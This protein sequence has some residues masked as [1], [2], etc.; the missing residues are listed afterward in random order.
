MAKSP[1]VVIFIFSAA[2]STSPTVRPRPFRDNRVVGEIRPPRLDRRAVGFEDLLIMEGLGRLRAPKPLARDRA[3]DGAAFAALQRVGNGG[4]GDGAVEQLKCRDGAGNARG[5]YEGPRGVVDQHRIGG[6]RLKP[7]EP[8]LD[9]KLPGRAAGHGPEQLGRG[10]ARERLLVKRLVTHAQGHDHMIDMRVLKKC[11]D[12]TAQNSFSADAAILFRAPLAEPG[13][14]AA[15]ARHD[16][17]RMS[18]PVLVLFL[19][20]VFASAVAWPEAVHRRRHYRAP[21][22]PPSAFAQAVIRLLRRGSL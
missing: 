20:R 22:K 14:H 3:R 8:R 18:A 13:T 9:R 16:Q 11:A 1:A 15:A 12:G 2:F 10:K 6:E 17:R 4:G 5:A 21:W 7:V 19:H